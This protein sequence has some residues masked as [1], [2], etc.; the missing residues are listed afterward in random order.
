MDS[1]LLIA[2]PDEVCSLHRLLYF[3]VFFPLSF[4]LFLVAG[5]SSSLPLPRRAAWRPLGH[6]AEHA[7]KR[8]CH[9]SSRETRATLVT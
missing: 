3:S 4:S 8:A 6:A 5:L 1:I 9:A 2:R 7:T